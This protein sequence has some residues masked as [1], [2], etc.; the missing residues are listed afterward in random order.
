MKKMKTCY[1]PGLLSKIEKM[2]N[3]KWRSG[4]NPTEVPEHCIDYLVLNEMDL[5]ELT[6]SISPFD[7]LKIKN[8]SCEKFLK[9]CIRIAPKKG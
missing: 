8:V 3:I 9:E 7:S 5:G 6:A 1:E 4:R 2:S